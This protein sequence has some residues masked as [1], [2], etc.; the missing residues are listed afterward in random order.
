MTP[1]AAGDSC[2]Y[3]RSL[4][5]RGGMVGRVSGGGS[6]GGSG[7]RR[8]GDGSALDLNAVLHQNLAA[9]SIDD[10]PSPGWSQLKTDVAGCVFVSF[11]PRMID[12]A[13]LPVFVRVA[14][15]GCCS[16]CVYN[17]V[18][19]RMVFCDVDASR[20]NQEYFV[21]IAEATSRSRVGPFI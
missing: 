2:S 12:N 1:V 4:T 15:F 8:G 19:C 7:A 5:A 18:P 3:D 9:L 14:T 17:D 11:W 16:L 6:G 13:S 20:F 10:D 21:F